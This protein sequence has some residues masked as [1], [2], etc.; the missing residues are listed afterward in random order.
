ME[1]NKYIDW[2]PESNKPLG[3]ALLRHLVT[4]NDDAV[5]RALE[6]YQNDDGG[7][8]H[9]LE[10]DIQMPASSV[11]ATDV[12]VNLLEDIA[13]SPRKT[14]M[15]KRIVAYFETTYDK[16]TRSWDIVPP[17]VDDHPHAVWWNYDAID[18][19]TYGNP[20]PEV[21]GFLAQHRGHLRGLDLQPLVD[22]VVAHIN[23]APLET[24]S[25]HSLLS[26]LRFYMRVD[27]VVQASV[28]ERLAEL[29]EALVAFRPDEWEGYVL[30]PYKVA[31]IAPEFLREHADALA[32]NITY[33]EAMLATGLPQPAWQ[34]YQYDDVFQRIKDDWVAFLTY[35]VLKTIKRFGK[36]H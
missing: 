23:E 33:H 11:A 3:E 32:K 4:P 9:G 16:E 31:D 10:P 26:M 1:I 8:G 30:E 13:P 7:F 19:F 35:G 14:A 17:E 20:N 18:G 24:I 34:W 5:L 29:V 6:S 22:K 28:E 15:I 25:M 12:A 21:A 2:L 36:Q 27:K